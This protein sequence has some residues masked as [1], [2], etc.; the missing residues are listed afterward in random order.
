MNLGSGVCV[1]DHSLQGR[2]AGR[3]PTDRPTFSLDDGAKLSAR[4]LNRQWSMV[5]SSRSAETV[6]Y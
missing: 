2:Q 4:P 6:F 1:L 3:L 5:A